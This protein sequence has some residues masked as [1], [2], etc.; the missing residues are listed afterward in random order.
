MLIKKQCTALIEDKKVHNLSSPVKVDGE[1]EINKLMYCLP[2]QH[3]T[4]GKH[5]FMVVGGEI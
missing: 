5:I 4:T 3:C 1:K 2:L